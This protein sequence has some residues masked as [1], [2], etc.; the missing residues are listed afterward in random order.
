MPSKF[1]KPQAANSNRKALKSKHGEH[2]SVAHTMNFSKQG[3]HEL[4]IHVE[5]G[6][7][8]SQ[9]KIT[10]GPDDGHGV[11]GTPLTTAQLQILIDKKKQ[12]FADEASYKEITRR[13]VENIK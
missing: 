11:R 9:H 13:N 10:M 2:V 7:V 4:H 6:K 8:K 3:V 1:E 5:C 12:D